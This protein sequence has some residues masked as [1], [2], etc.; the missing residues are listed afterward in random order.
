MTKPNQ[1][2][3]IILNEK[4]I[5]KK[6]L[7][8][9]DN[10]KTIRKKIQDKVKDNYIFLDIEGHDINAEKEEHI[11]LEDISKDKII[12]I[13]TIENNNTN[14]IK[15]LLNDEEIHSIDYNESQNLSEIRN[16]IK[17]KV[18]KDFTFLDEDGNDISI[19]E[20]K[21]FSISDIL[22]N[23]TIELKCN[24]TSAPTPLNECDEKESIKEEIKEEKLPKS[25]ETK[26]E[27]NK[28]KIQ[29]FLKYEILEQ[30]D[31]LTIYKYS[32]VERI[33]KKEHVFQYFYDKY[34]L[35]DYQD[36]YIVL[37]CGKTGDGKTT[38]INAIFNIVKGVE[39]E[40]NYR[41]ILITE[42]K[43]KTG[44]AESQTDGA[45]IYYLRDYNNKPV[46][47][48]DSQGYA[49][50]RNQDGQKNYDYDIDNAF[51]YIFSNVIDH[52]NSVIFISK[53]S[54]NR[55]DSVTR[56]IFASVTKLFADDINEN[57]VILTTHADKHSI[58]KEPTFI[59]CIKTQDDFAKLE[60]RLDKNYWFNIDSKSI[61]D[62]DNDKLTKY[63]FKKAKS[64]YEDK[65]KK[66]NPKNI[67]KSSEVLKG[68][69]ESRILVE[70]LNL[71]FQKLIVQQE[72]LEIKEK[73]IDRKI[74][75]IE[76]LERNINDLTNDINRLNPKELEEKLSAINSEINQKMN[77][78]LHE[79]EEELIQTLTISCKHH[80]VCH[81]CKRNC[82]S[83][84]EC[85]FSV[86]FKR[87]KIFTFFGQ[88]C[89]VC[90]CHKDSHKRD[91]YEYEYIK[92]NKQ[93]YT[94]DEINMEKQKNENRKKRIMD[95][96]DKN[97]NARTNVEK[98]LNELNTNKKI[99]VLEQEKIKEE[100]NDIQN[101]IKNIN[102]QIIFIIIK[103][104]GISEKIKDN[105]MVD[106]FTKSED[107]Y[108][109]GLIN[110][111]DTM[112]IKEK[113]K[114][115][116]I[117]QIKENNRI[118]RETIRIDKKDLMKLDDTQ[119]AGLLK[120]IIPNYKK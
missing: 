5:G 54:N 96:M 90:G 51:S 88:K 46:I 50:T 80:N 15:I 77:E 105:E 53:A 30:R 19:E 25:E 93:K 10:L 47:F 16:I 44:Q 6:P 107:D 27:E 94:D 102:K 74:E 76:R 73:N 13:K 29:D 83:P 98:K 79:K 92:R 72:N 103:L 39:L 41:F 21:D 99:L 66:L 68:R 85:I 1:I 117:R 9:N 95:E 87:C 42:P 108:I 26:K 4:P 52:I 113:E 101:K 116:K 86:I 57:F 58:D 37:F 14:K 3:K 12:H 115:S 118:F 8:L 36:A 78:F 70:Q 106:N 89:E 49:D 63:S 61:L 100:K 71:T 120:I 2:T 64:L 111:M 110:Q 114:I 40:D 91:K 97:N 119:L 109:D 22:N 11:T 69:I 55:V 45:H 56:Y 20:E 60:K 24:D 65:I 38:A 28:I 34:E 32:N 67:L 18:N 112:N 7:S 81:D 23:N 59:S 43:K 75:D 31:D 104:Q 33:S 84:C 35:N 82:D 17:D 62:N 48:I